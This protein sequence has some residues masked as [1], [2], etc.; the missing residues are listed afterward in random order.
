MSFEVGAVLEDA[1][2]QAPEYCFTKDAGIAETAGGHH[3]DSFIPRSALR[4]SCWFPI[5]CREL[6]KL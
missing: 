4:T 5:V 1:A 6:I 2:W 3:D